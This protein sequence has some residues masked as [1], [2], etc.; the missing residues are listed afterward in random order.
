M[1]IF[2]VLA[3]LPLLILTGC[4]WTVHPIYTEKDVYFEPA[5]VGIWQ[6]DKGDI[7]EFRRGNSNDYEVIF[8]EIKPG[9]DCVVQGN[10]AKVNGVRVLDFYPNATELKE[11]SCLDSFFL[12]MH[13]FFR[14]DQIEPTLELSAVDYGWMQKIVKN[15]PD[16]IAHVEIKPGILLTAETEELQ[17]F[18]SKHFDD[19]GAFFHAH[20][21]RRAE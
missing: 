2:S 19:E 3:V 14:V 17:K 7:I 20:S 11:A 4:V 12:P 15:D 21:W 1:R 16:I 5:L 10:L 18:W 8:R 13:M 9:K 6:S